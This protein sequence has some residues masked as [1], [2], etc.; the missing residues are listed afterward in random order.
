V[1]AV[2]SIRPGTNEDAEQIA[3]FSR[4]TFYES[5]ASQN[6]P[7]DMDKFLREQF[8][9]ESLMAE[10]GTDENIFLL[11]YLNEQLVGYVNL[12]KS[13][14]PVELK[15][16]RTIEIARL[17]TLQQMIG[18]GVGKALMQKAIDTA[19]HNSIEV[20]WLGVWEHNQRAINFYTRFGFSKFGEHD[21]VLGNDHQCDWLMKKKI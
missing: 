20:I 21:F 17:Y 15:P 12:R 18:K 1:T 5:F 19:Q 10:V 3:D 6:R 8:T 13:P 9:K 2:L 11:A 7:E 4:H 16:F 14:S